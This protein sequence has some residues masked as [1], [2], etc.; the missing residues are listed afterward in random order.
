MVST[1]P[2]GNAT[3]GVT[4]D[5]TNA[6]NM[7]NSDMTNNPTTDGNMAKI[8]INGNEVEIDPNA[9]ILDAAIQA[10]VEIPTLC[11][12]KDLNDIGACRVCVVEIEGED[13]LA[14]SCN[15]TVRDGMV[16]HTDTKKVQDSRRA[17]LQLLLSQHDLNCAYCKRNG[18][19]RFQKLLL[20]AGLIEWDASLTF[21]MEAPS[22]YE[23]NIAKGRRAMWPDEAIIQRNGNRC[24]KCGRCISACERLENIGVWQFKGTG[25]RSTVGVANGALPRQAGCVA[26]GQCI[27]HCPT[28]GLTER[29]DTKLLL[30]AIADPA[31]TTVVQIAP[32]TRTSWG[33]G[34]GAK[35]GELSVERMVAAL[36]AM[37]VDYV[38]D[39][40]LAA[41]LTIM[42]EG[43]ELLE[44]LGSRTPDENGITWPM[45]TSCCPAW[46]EHAKNS[47]SDTL[48][49][50]S[51]AKSPMMMFGAVAKT[52]F[53]DKKGLDPKD[54]F[55]V[56]MMPCTA[57][58]GEIK[59]PMN[60]HEDI[61][62]MDAALTTRELIRIIKESGID[63]N[64]LEDMPL[65]DPLGTFTGAGVIFGTTGGVM[66]AALRTAYF[67]ATGE[68]APPDDFIFDVSE[69]GAWT[70]GTFDMKGTSVR[71][72]VAHGLSNAN[73]LLDAIRAGVVEYEFVEIMACPSGCAGGGGQPID[74][75]DRELG[76]KRGQ[77]LRKIDKTQKTIRYSH[78]NPQIQMLY[79]EFFGKPC[80]ELAH[81]LLH[82]VHLP[83]DAGAKR[84]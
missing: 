8:T 3:T 62:D 51:T 13:R 22:P 81:H 33:V 52:W 53:A 60:S 47:H 55:S 48:A 32:A 58:K 17:T 35:D 71:C 61:A 50:L 18:T 21:M 31:K 20:D 9:T 5:A 45:F 10:Q 64:A 25:M 28:A 79:D 19:C 16:I 43:T 6:G 12:F 39:T 38:F 24:V 42:E 37:G 54:I 11:Y 66:E 84:G 2:A 56:A 78:E 30:D 14:A 49:H 7:T 77:T 1:E 23:K 72:A 82:T 69:H 57:K 74:G 4:T 67:V 46:V 36:K 34:L 63:V 80:S 40:C 75:S 70:E 76:M 29:D 15:T 59:L 26:C 41:D 27:T 44:G 73:A 83:N 68:L 65:D